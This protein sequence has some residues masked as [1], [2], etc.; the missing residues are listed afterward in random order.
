MWDGD[1]RTQNKVKLIEFIYENK[2]GIAESGS[3]AGK[4]SPFEQRMF[5]G[6]AVAGGR[7]SDGG[8]V[9]LVSTVVGH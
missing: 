2:N 4:N 8:G 9:H 7:I 5:N 1:I 3:E 6:I